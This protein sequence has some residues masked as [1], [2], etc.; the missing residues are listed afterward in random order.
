MTKREKIIVFLMVLSLVYGF[1]V[2]FLEGPVKR[3]QTNTTTSK[4]EL[5]NKFIIDIADEAKDGLTEI[6]AYIIENIS[7]KWT[8]D[9]LLNTR[10]PN[11]YIEVSQKT[12]EILK[13]ITY[14]GYLQMGSRNLAIINGTE[15]E[16]GEEL[17]KG[18]FTV[19][20]IYPNRVIIVLRGGKV[21]HAIPLEETQ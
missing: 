12:P 19:G 7:A 4:L 10:D 5:I 14:S 6:D 13:G 15:Y 8:K 20:K 16:A 3:Q 1:Y 2:F 17:E 21:K 11:P 9:P 18:G